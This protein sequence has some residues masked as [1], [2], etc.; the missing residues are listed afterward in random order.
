MSY[1]SH[2]RRNEKG[3]SIRQFVLECDVNVSLVGMR[4]RNMRGEVS[5][6]ELRGRER[7]DAQATSPQA[8]G[9][10]A[11][12]MTQSDGSTMPLTAGEAAGPTRKCANLDVAV[13]QDYAVAL[14]H[15]TGDR[16]RGDA[17]GRSGRSHAES[18]VA[19][20]P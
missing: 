19:D 13:R 10:P 11:E 7:P 6:I 18:I 20:R 5:V 1:V 16:W 14:Q 17:Y 3:E 15:W 12:P 2:W 8:A 9:D 4:D